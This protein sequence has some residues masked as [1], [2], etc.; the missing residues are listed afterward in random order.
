MLRSGWKLKWLLRLTCGLANI[1]LLRSSLVMLRLLAILFLIVRLLLRIA[2]RLIWTAH[3]IL[4]WRAKH[5]AGALGTARFATNW[6]M[7]RAKG[8][9]TNRRPDRPFFFAFQQGWD[10]D[11]LRAHGGGQRRRHRHP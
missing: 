6:E 11:G 10:G 7:L 1:N 5:S 4:T 9:W 2:F 8:K 3:L